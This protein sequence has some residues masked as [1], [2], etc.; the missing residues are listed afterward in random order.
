MLKLR[1][2]H[3][4]GSAEQDASVRRG[5]ILVAPAYS[6]GLAELACTPEHSAPAAGDLQQNPICIDPL[7]PRTPR[8]GVHVDMDRLDLLVGG[9]VERSGIGVW[10]VKAATDRLPAR[11]TGHDEV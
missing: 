4:P 10:E 1:G 8:F 9:G 3:P 5:L 11:T 7:W 6:P 2:S